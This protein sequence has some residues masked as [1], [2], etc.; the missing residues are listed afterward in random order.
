MQPRRSSATQCWQMTC[1][2]ITSPG[3]TGSSAGL[4]PLGSPSSL[5]ACAAFGGQ[6][7]CTWATGSETAPSS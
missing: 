6:P 3:S 1:R 5:A 2:A 4:T 7:C